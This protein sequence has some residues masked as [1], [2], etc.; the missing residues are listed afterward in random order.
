MNENMK[1][2]P[3]YQ[4]G[5]FKAISIGFFLLLVG[6]IFVVTP[7]LFGEIIDFFGD[8]SLVKVPHTD[9]YFPAPQIPRQHLTFYQAVGQFSVAWSVFLVIVLALRFVF[10]SSWAKRSETMGDLI[11]WA[12]TGFLI[13]SFLVENTE[14]F[15][16]W[17]TILILI[18]VSLIVRAAVMA[19][20]RL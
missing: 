15:I 8:F 6:A 16:F 10:P 5:V 17:S 2:L 14:W 19:I 4:E 3:K 9:I 20:S 7:D 1:T 12:G 11:F 18:G 13:Q